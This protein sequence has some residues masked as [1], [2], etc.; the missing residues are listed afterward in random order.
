MRSRVKEDRDTSDAD[1]KAAVFRVGDKN[2]RVI[3]TA[4]SN[5]VS[6]GKSSHACRPLKEVLVKVSARVRKRQAARLRPG[7]FGR[8]RRPEQVA[9]RKTA[10]LASFSGLDI[11]FQIEKN[12]NHDHESR[13]PRK[14]TE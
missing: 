3:S 1:G 13:F 12:E 8:A 5:L 2:D 4:D 9:E 14:P 11:P 10:H 6:F 7:P